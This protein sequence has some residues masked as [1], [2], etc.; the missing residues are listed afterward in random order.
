MA[1]KVTKGGPEKKEI[2]GDTSKMVNDLSGWSDTIARIG[3]ENRRREDERLAALEAELPV[4]IAGLKD[5]QSVELLGL[6]RQHSGSLWNERENAIRSAFA[7]AIVTE[8]LER[9]KV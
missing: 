2:T 7:D 6:L 9:M 5:R 3:D 1:R 8:C 4:Q